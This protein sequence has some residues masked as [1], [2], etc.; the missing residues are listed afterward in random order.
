MITDPNDFSR[1][2]LTP[3][4]IAEKAAKHR[5]HKIIEP[6]DEADLENIDKRLIGKSEEQLQEDFTWADDSVEEEEGT[7]VYEA[8]A[9]HI[10]ACSEAVVNYVS[11]NVQTCDFNTTET[12]IEITLPIPV[13]AHAVLA[14]RFNSRWTLDSRC[15]QIDKVRDIL[16]TIILHPTVRDQLNASLQTVL[17][18]AQA[19]WEV[20]FLT[21]DDDDVI[22]GGEN[23]KGFSATLLIGKQQNA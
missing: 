5:F 7:E 19:A 10:A 14:E 15:M 21:I 8:S 3:E 2:K 23:D 6:L 16:E 13:S 20:V 17:P 12:G 4:E 18:P 9:E 11:A 1:P 22:V